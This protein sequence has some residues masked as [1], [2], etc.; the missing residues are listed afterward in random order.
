MDYVEIGVQNRFIVVPL[1]HAED[2]VLLRGHALAGLEN[3][4]DS[5]RVACE[6][7]MVVCF[8]RTAGSRQLHS[9]CPYRSADR[10][11]RRRQVQLRR[12]EF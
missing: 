7:H 5:V 11:Y 10:F 9:A 2:F 12:R 1:E 6:N 3:R 8:R 4:E